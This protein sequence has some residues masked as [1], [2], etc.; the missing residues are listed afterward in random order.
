[1][2]V[3]V[4][5]STTVV[6]HVAV[7]EDVARANVAVVVLVTV[8]GTRPK[9]EHS[10]DKMLVAMDLK[11]LGIDFD[12]AVV[13][14]VARA[15]AERFRR[16]DVVVVVSTVLV[17]TVTE[18]AVTSM[19]VVDEATASSTIVTRSVFKAVLVIMDVRTSTMTMSTVVQDTSVVVV[20]V[21][22]VQY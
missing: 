15:S 3:A 21:V 13:H 18:V 4:V 12:I 14:F 17:V 9:Q 5:T 19:T 8:G 10:F 2:L 7:A 6:V 1:M 16:G 22:L 11:M 20:V